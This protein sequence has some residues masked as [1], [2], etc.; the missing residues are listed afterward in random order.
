MGEWSTRRYDSEA[1][2]EVYGVQLGYNWQ[3]GAMLIGVEADLQDSNLSGTSTFD[4]VTPVAG[5]PANPFSARVRQK[6][7]IDYLATLRARLG[8]ASARWLVY[9]IAG[10]ASARV[11]TTVNY[12][13]SYEAAP[14]IDFDEVDAEK[15]S[16]RTGFVLRAGAEYLYYDLGESSQR[17]NVSARTPSTGFT[18]ISSARATA[19][20]TGSLL[21]LGLN[22]RF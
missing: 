8:Y 7:S 4:T 18:A 16:T 19:E 17:Y 1:E 20:W 12:S 9:G 2:D 3:R 15:R 22:Y 11:D 10:L 13:G 14:T 5:Y 21:R 6:G